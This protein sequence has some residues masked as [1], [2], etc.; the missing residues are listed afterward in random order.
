MKN[1]LFKIFI[2]II[3]NFIKFFDI[4]LKLFN[5]N[6]FYLRVVDQLKDEFLEIIIRNKLVK[7]YTPSYISAWR[8][9]TLFT[10]EPETIDWI[11]NFKKI[12]NKIIFWD[13]GAN[14]GI[15]SLYAA[16]IHPLAKI[17]AHEPNFKNLSILAK[18]ISINDFQDKIHINQL[19][20]TEKS[21][22]SDLFYEGNDI[23]G[24]AD[25]SFS[26]STNSH[27]NSF[28]II[29]A[30]IDFLIKNKIIEYPNY[31]KIDIDGLENLVLKGARN[32]LNYKYLTSILIEI[33]ISENKEFKW[34]DDQLNTYG[35]NLYSKHHCNRNIY[36][37]IYYKKVC[38]L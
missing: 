26:K 36:N 4:F 27:I 12:N 37:H 31:I 6:F 32:A 29:G 30:N 34:I 10:K 11:N 28:K 22:V 33:D 9:K 35:F 21:I 19:P 16:A 13:I 8:V 2:F 23:E 24:G 17:F 14:I 18:N 15:Y 3:R 38:E 20:L 5:F 1:K 25:S 7:F